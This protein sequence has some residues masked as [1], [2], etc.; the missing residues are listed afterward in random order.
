MVGPGSVILDSGP[1]SVVGGL[2]RGTKTG[3]GRHQIIIGSLLP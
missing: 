2:T 3:M 1:I